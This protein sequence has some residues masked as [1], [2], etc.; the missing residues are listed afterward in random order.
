MICKDWWLVHANRKP[1][2][3]GKR[4]H[5]EALK[6]TSTLPLAPFKSKET[7]VCKWVKHPNRGR[8]LSEGAYPDWEKL[9]SPSGAWFTA[10]R[11][12]A[13][14]ADFSQLAISFNCIVAFLAEPFQQPFRAK[15]RRQISF[16]LT[17][18]L[19]REWESGLMAQGTVW[20]ISLSGSTGSSVAAVGHWP[21]AQCQ[22]DW[23]QHCLTVVDSLLKLCSPLHSS[24]RMLTFAIMAAVSLCV[25][26]RLENTD[27]L[28]YSDSQKTLSELI[29]GPALSS[30]N[31][32]LNKT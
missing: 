24:V 30:E 11:D 12:E 27:I 2:Y 16:F 18:E 23:L 6:K 31:K 10:L 22:R 17:L 29:P 26:S 19:S 3:R 9:G 32:N 25:N 5:R 20:V 21:P 28:T 13:G 4:V 14:R 15:G 1:D 7:K 8:L